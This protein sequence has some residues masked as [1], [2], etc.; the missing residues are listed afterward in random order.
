MN[1]VGL[2][3]RLD[4]S[5]AALSRWLGLPRA[6]LPARHALAPL[7]LFL[8]GSNTASSI[9]AEAILQHFAE[10]RVRAASAGESPEGQVNP[11]TLECLRIHGVASRGLRSKGQ[12]EFFG[13]RKPPIRFIITLGEFESIG[14]DSDH[15]GRRSV[16]GHW[17]MED[18]ANARGP[19]SDFRLGFEEAFRTLALRIHKFL[20]LPLGRLTDQALSRE[21][22]LIGNES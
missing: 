20:T 6:P 1:K 8:C 21:L 9:M 15:S 10:A 2:T 17:G 16:T 3:S 18:P 12:C 22:A 7:V 11:Y 19:D 5:S 13:P 4:G 14:V